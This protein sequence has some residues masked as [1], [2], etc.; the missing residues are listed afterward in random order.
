V[1]RFLTAHQHTY[2]L[3]QCLKAGWQHTF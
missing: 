1:S 2:R 3:F